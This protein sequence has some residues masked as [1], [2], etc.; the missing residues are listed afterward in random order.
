MHIDLKN[1]AKIELEVS[2]IRISLIIRNHHYESDKLLKFVQ[3]Y[4]QRY[5]AKIRDAVLSH[6][7]FVVIKSVSN[8]SKLECRV[9]PLYV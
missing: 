5:P 3:E 1:K 9:C 2:L 7:A 4:L 6:V 8:T